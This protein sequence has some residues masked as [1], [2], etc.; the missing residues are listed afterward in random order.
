MKKLTLLLFAFITISISTFAQDTK[1]AV[2]IY[3]PA[4]NAQADLDAAIAK[5][6]KKVNMYLCR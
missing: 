5:A 3:N 2:K 4:A 1:E 6:K